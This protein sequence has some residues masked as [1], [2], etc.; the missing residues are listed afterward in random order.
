MGYTNPSTRKVNKNKS[1]EVE[2]IT[3]KKFWVLLNNKGRLVYH[4]TEGHIFLFSRRKDALDYLMDY[5][6]ENK[7]EKLD[8]IITK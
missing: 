2:T 1:P 8:V 6:P 3:S 7:I 5:C 4:K